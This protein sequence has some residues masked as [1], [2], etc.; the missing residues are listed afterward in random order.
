MIDHL[1]DTKQTA[2]QTGRTG[3]TLMRYVKAGNFPKPVYIGCRK[4]WYQK[5]VTQWL[6][7]N[8]SSTPNFDNFGSK[9]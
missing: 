7:D 9:S 8:I 4:F 6:E 2:L 1:C 3:N 5:Q